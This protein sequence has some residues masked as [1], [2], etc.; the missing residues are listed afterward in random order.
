MC[1]KGVCV[2]GGWIRTDHIKYGRTVEATFW[3]YWSL[4]IVLA[5]RT[6]KKVLK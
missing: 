1:V 5:G 4:E 3:K 2:W 6:V